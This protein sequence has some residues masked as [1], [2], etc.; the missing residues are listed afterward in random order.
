[1]TGLPRSRSLF[2][3]ALS[4]VITG[5]APPAFGQGPPTSA[6]NAADVSQS[7]RLMATA[8]KLKAQG[9]ID[10]AAEQFESAYKLVP[11]AA[12]LR[13]ALD[14]YKQLNQSA[15]QLSAAQRLLD[16]HAKELSKPEQAALKKLVETAKAH[17]G[18]IDLVAESGAAVRLD[19]REI[20]TTPLPGPISVDAGKHTLVLKKEGFEPFEK[21]VEVTA[22]TTASVEA[23]LEPTITT[24]EIVVRE[25]AGLPVTVVIDGV[26]VGPAPYKGS[27]PLGKHQLSVRSATHASEPREVTLVKREVADLTVEATPT[28]GRLEVSTSDNHG[29]VR[30]DGKL[31]GDG[32][33]AGDLTA[34]D[35]VVEVTREG[36]KPFSQKVSIASGKAATLRVALQRQVV[37]VPPPTTSDGQGLYGAVRLA[38]QVQLTRAGNELELGCPQLTDTAN[39]P[40]AGTTSPPN[41]CSSGSPAGGGLFGLLGYGWKYVGVEMM[42]GGTTDVTRAEAHIQGRKDNGYDILRVGGMA[43]LRAR[44][45]VQTKALRASLAAG[46]GLAERIVFMDSATTDYFSPALSVDLALG[47]RFSSTTTFTLGSMLWLEGAGRPGPSTSRPEQRDFRLFSGTQTML[48]PYLGFEFGP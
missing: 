25:A 39:P 32:S 22:R 27:L 26:D 45:V 41:T 21:S 35:H 38:G 44:G 34:G 18:Q 11:S 16:K 15:N 8:S 14:C 20:G 47:I 7:K 6:A 30:I 43:A 12:P 5:T 40:P 33:F 13:E 4:L 19:E 17:V 48:L 2:A 3:V 24:A 9:A 1:M 28:T 10:L 23:K 36:H 42:L 31:V 37:E 46:P 29:I